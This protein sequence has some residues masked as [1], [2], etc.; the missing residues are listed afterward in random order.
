MPERS[1]RPMD[2]ISAFAFALELKGVTEATFRE[3]TG[4]GSENEVIE[5]K[6]QGPK[7]VTVIHKIP[8]NLKWQNINLK[9]GITDN[10]DLWTWRQKVIDG[11]IE[12]ARM[13]GSVVGYNENGNEVIRYNFINGWPCKWTSTGVNSQ[14]AEVIIEEIEIA[15]EGLTRAS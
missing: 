15:H 7:G 10:I 5:Y 3:A 8:G 11:Q 9:R 4:F 13:N 12:A 14:G 2:P 6:Q 1:D